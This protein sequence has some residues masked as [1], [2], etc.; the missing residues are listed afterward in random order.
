[1]IAVNYSLAAAEASKADAVALEGRLDS[2]R[3][4]STSPSKGSL[5]AI[6]AV[7]TF[8]RGKPFDRNMWHERSRLRREEEMLAKYQP[9]VRLS[10]ASMA[11]AALA[12]AC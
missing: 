2:A 8:V 10:T 11:Q 7:G 1:M 6:P 5:S 3:Q 4:L 12:R 9:L